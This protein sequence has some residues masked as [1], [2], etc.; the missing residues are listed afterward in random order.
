MDFPPKIAVPICIEQGAVYLY[1]LETKNRDGTLY[2]GDRFMIILNA[3]PKT[4]TVLILATITSQ[5]E[6]QR[7]FIK[8]VGESPET[9][10]EITQGDFARLNKNSVVNCNN[11]YETSLPELISKIENGGK[12]FTVKL[13]KNKISE[14]I[15]GVLLSNQVTPEQKRLLI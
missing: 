9:L 15:K 10:V 5:I 4:D 1:Q 2:K 6:N 8:R 13:P 11:I 7:K 14:I 3:N 12:L